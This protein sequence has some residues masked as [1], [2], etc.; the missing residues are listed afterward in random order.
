MMGTAPNMNSTKSG[1]PTIFSG[2]VL[3]CTPNNA[4][5]RM[6]HFRCVFEAGSKWLPAVRQEMA[7]GLQYARHISEIPEIPSENTPRLRK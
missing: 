2:S 7:K 6:L 4:H 1:K 3:Y 5:L